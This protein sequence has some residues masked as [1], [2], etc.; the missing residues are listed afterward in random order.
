MNGSVLLLVMAGLCGAGA[1]PVFVNVEIQ[2]KLEGEGTALTDWANVLDN[3]PTGLWIVAPGT[4]EGAPD[5]VGPPGGPGPARQKASE[6]PGL[7]WELF[8]GQDKGLHE[9]AEKYRG[10]TVLVKG[11]VEVLDDWWLA[12]RSRAP[13]TGSR[14]GAPRIIVKVTDLQLP[15]GKP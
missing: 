4:R 9:L 11:T 5:G 7:R 13:R 12:S 14:T 2:G 6:P 15:K 3:K 1:P 10:Q 8:L